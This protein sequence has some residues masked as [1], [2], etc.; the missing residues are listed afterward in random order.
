MRKILKA[1]ALLALA[2]A[3][4]LCLS[5]CGLTPGESGSAPSPDAFTVENASHLT[6]RTE[7]KLQQH[8]EK[9]GQETGCA[10]A[11]EYL[12]AA[13]AVVANPAALH[14]LQAEDGDDLYFLESTGEFVVVSP[15][16]YIRTYYLTDRDYFERQ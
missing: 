13:N 9:H 11:E 6:F 5:G 10:T 15:A 4:L 7:N 12:T 8:F 3:A 14:K 16:G 2:L 1:R